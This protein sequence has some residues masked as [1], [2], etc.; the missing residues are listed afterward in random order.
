MIIRGSIK[1]LSHQYKSRVIPT[2][3]IQNER[4]NIMLKANYGIAVEGNQ[5]GI[6]RS[7]YAIDGKRAAKKFNEGVERMINNVKHTFDRKV[8]IGNGETQD[9]EAE[10]FKVTVFIYASNNPNCN[11]HEQFVINETCSQNDAIE[12]IRNKLETIKT[13]VK[14]W[15]GVEL[16]PLSLPSYCYN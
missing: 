3:G 14:Q 10:Q 6:Q 16:S 13:A 2:H 12:Q 15:Y 7:G 9:K 11:V 8:Y 4:G 1:Y 5:N